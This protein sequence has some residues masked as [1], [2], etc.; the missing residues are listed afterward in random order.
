MTKSADEGSG[1][2]SYF[3][4]KIRFDISLKWKE[5]WKKY[6]L[7]FCENKKNNLNDG[8]FYSKPGG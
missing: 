8:R 1:Y 2:F 6:S 3:P 4:L 7:I 5:I